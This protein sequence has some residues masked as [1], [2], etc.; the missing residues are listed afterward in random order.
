MQAHI[1]IQC[2]CGSFKWHNWE[3]WNNAWSEDSEAHLLYRLCQ[4]ANSCGAWEG[5][6][7]GDSVNW[8]DIF[9]QGLSI[10]G[11]NDS[12]Q[13]MD[14]QYIETWVNPAIRAGQSKGKG[15]R[16]SSDRSRSRRGRIDAARG[17]IERLEDMMRRMDRISDELF[18]IRQ[19]IHDLRRDQ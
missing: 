12:T 18:H 19:H 10:K 15:K 5:R 3:K 14:N 13:V 16:A 6:K 11:Y 7:E 2:L 4:H 9:R 17:R 1:G 8:H